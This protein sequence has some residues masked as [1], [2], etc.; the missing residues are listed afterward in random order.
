MQLLAAF[1][2]TIVGINQPSTVH[3]SLGDAVGT[4]RIVWSSSSDAFASVASRGS[5]PS[6][7]YGVN[8]G[9]LE[10]VAIASTATLLNT[11]VAKGQPNRTIL[12]HRATLAD[13]APRTRFF[14]QVNSGDNSSN[15][16]SVLSFTT[17]APHTSRDSASPRYGES[18][19][20]AVFGDMGVK[21]QEGANWTRMRLFEHRAKG[22]ID[23]VLHVGDIAYDL[24]ENG[25]QTGDEF[26]HDMEPLASST[27]YMTVPGNHERDC[28][29]VHGIATANCP[30]PPY[31]NFRARFPPPNAAHS[32]CAVAKE[33]ACSSFSMVDGAP[34][35]WSMD[36]GAAHVVGLNTDWYTLP[37]GDA[38]SAKILAQRKWL[39]NDLNQV[40]RSNTPW[41]IALGHQ[42]MY[43]SHD[44]GHRSQAKIIRE[45]RSPY[46]GLE[47]IFHAHEVDL[48]FAGHEHVYEHFSRIYNSSTKEIDGK[49]GTAHIVVGNAGNREFPY[50]AGFDEKMPPYER[51]RS[52]FPSGFGL[53]EV[54]RTAMRFRQF[55]ARNGS[56]LDAHTYMR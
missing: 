19:T 29:I 18:V 31:T 49:R 21:E 3:I 15:S 33:G 53:L 11:D 2:S 54:N 23:A 40:N 44:S 47:A 13:L 38:A 50:K 52:P 10:H 43:S 51:F 26:L 28:P 56:I 27:P 36:I 32:D 46:T 34:L 42:M 37:A 25:G 8:A 35:W 14:Y 16:S 12:V 20:F 6:V 4:M 45:G 9:S 55:N 48:Y 1:L 41:V 24:R 5:A 39:E 17:K 22:D 7:R 30:V